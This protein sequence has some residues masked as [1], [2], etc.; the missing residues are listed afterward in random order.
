[1]SEPRH[2]RHSLPDDEESRP[3]TGATEGGTAVPDGAAD[4]AVAVAERE[5]RPARAGWD[6]SIPPPRPKYSG[7]ELPPMYEEP[8]PAPASVTASFWVLLAS[9]F[10]GV[11]AAALAATGL[12]A[13]RD[14]LRSSV[15][16]QDLDPAVLDDV[17][18]VTVFGSLAATVVLAVPVGVLAAVMR[19]GRGGARIALVLLG[20]LALPVL[21]VTWSVVPTGPRIGLT[22]QLLLLLT[23]LVLMFVRGAGAWFRSQRR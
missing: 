10:A 13:L 11:A 20:V 6:P 4:A 19:G 18:T 21:V 15:A 17:V 12:D 1:M 23:G 22:V 14:R 8:E 16:G 3:S 5:P 9:G 2:G 7:P